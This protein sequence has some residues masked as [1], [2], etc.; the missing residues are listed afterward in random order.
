MS[1]KFR[2]DKRSMAE[3]QLSIEQA[4]A[5]I[6]TAVGESPLPL[7]RHQY[8]Q[9]L[10][11]ACA[12]AFKQQAETVKERGDAAGLWQER[13]ETLKAALHDVDPQNPL[14]AAP[15]EQPAESLPS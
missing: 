6:A 1:K 4:L 9:S 12:H 3:R 15:S 11:Q 10:L 7:A 2:K 8:Y 5:E 14:I 13:A